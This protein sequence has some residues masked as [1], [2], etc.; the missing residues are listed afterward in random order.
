MGIRYGRCVVLVLTVAAAGAA[1]LT[2]AND[3]NNRSIAALARG[4]YLDAEQWS[5]Q[6]LEAWRLLGTAFQP[7]YATSLLNLGESVCGQGRWREAGTIYE[8][9]L[10]INR[11]ILGDAHQ[12][13]ILNLDALANVRMQT[14][15]LEGASALF[16]E[17]LDI[18]RL[19]FPGSIYLSHTLTGL[20]MLAE[21]EGHLDAALPSAE[22]ALNVALAANGESID[23]TLAYMELSQ[24][25]RKAGRPERALPLIRK[26]LAIDRQL[27]GPEHPSTASLL[28][29]EGRAYLDEG[30][31]GLAEHDLT[32]AVTLLA[33]C[34]GCYYALA[35][36][37][38][39][40]GLLRLRQKRYEPAAG[41]LTEALELEEGSGRAAVGDIANT[42][43]LLADVREREHRSSEAAQLRRRVLDIQSYY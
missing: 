38:N 5:R 13:T 36:A 4:D 6:A 43:S 42:L 7:H 20:A 25:H 15:D 41:L 9:A 8:E 26:A 14:G 31:L 35:V 11:R 17:A 37:K 39:N 3:L 24:I 30:K 1:D 32:Q 12:H 40:L 34:K 27:L 33:R 29:Q 21:R 10:A 22:E 19:H 23:A 16:R 18:E 2:T 28:S